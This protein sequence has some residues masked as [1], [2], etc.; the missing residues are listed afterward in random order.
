MKGMELQSRLIAGQLSIIIDRPPTAIGVV[1]A[2]M[3]V[4]AAGAVGVVDAVGRVS[5]AIPAVGIGDGVGVVPV[6][7]HSAPVI[8]VTVIQ[9]RAIRGVLVAH[10]LFDPEILISATGGG[11]R[12]MRVLAELTEIVSRI[13]GDCQAK[14]EHDSDHLLHTNTLLCIRR[15]HRYGWYP[16]QATRDPVTAMSLQQQIGQIRSYQ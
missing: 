2:V 3:A 4:A 6:A 14:N 5:A 12:G 10:R 8:V 1:W 11:V 9:F 13:G 16:G 15:T 7:V